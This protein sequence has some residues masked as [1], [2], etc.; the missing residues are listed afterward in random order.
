MS[1][2]ALMAMCILFIELFIRLKMRDRIDR[3][4]KV[5]REAAKI[6]T[7]KE[8]SDKQKEVLVRR[9]SITLL[10]ATLTFSSLFLFM[11][12]AVFGVRLAFIYFSPGMKAHLDQSILSPVVMV[13]LTISAIIYVWLRGAIERRLQST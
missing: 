13:L 11:A 2:V 7:S 8:L 6:I 10:K 4:F 12:M 1:Y 9:S 5:S 3:I